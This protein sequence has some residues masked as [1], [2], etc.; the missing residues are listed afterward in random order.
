MADGAGVIA[1][2]HTRDGQLRVL[3]LDRWWA[4]AE[5][6]SRALQ[7]AGLVAAYGGF[8]DGEDPAALLRPDVALI[9]ARV[10]A[11]GVAAAVERIRRANTDAAIVLLRAEGSEPS[12]STAVAG[13]VARDADFSTVLAALERAADGSRLDAVGKPPQC[14]RGGK[15]AAFTA[16]SPRE[17]EVLALLVGGATNADAGAAL[18][19]SPQTV[20]TH[21]ANL[22]G[23]LSVNSRLE[24]ATWARREGLAPAV[25]TTR[26]GDLGAA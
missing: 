26:G 21:V 12:V 23:K 16:L 24:A 18:G 11:E 9:D 14:S 22:L 15:P 20:R 7:D 25:P 17:R 2:H 3:V 10:G 13:E 1:N 6:L 8:G 5:A 19:I 4:F